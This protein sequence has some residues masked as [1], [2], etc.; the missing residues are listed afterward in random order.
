LI[1]KP[2]NQIENYK[3]KLN[4]KNLIKNIERMGVGIIFLIF[5]GLISHI[6]WDLF[7]WSWNLISWLR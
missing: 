5:S 4:M 3:R 7:T 1:A 2:L 6:L